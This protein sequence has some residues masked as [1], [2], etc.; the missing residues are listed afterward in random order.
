MLK[1]PL[2]V[3]DF[4]NAVLV[5]RVLSGVRFDVHHECLAV[6]IA[7]RSVGCDRSNPVDSRYGRGVAHTPNRTTRPECRNVLFLAGRQRYDCVHV[8]LVERIGILFSA[9]VGPLGRCTRC[10]ESFL[11]KAGA[12]RRARH[13]PDG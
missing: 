2:I 1:M 12:C 8:H 11:A 3:R 9:F 6:K 13:S 10:A 4:E 5:V 7:I